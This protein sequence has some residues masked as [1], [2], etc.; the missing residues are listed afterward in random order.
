MFEWG[1]RVV[2]MGGIKKNHFPTL[3]GNNNL[4]ITKLEEGVCG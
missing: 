3:A 2:W 4:I 1:E